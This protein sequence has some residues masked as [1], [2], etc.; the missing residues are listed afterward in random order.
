MSYGLVT[1]AINAPIG[2]TQQNRFGQA[3]AYLPLSQFFLQQ[4][5][6]QKGDKK[7]EVL[8]G[9]QEP[10]K[11]PPAK[12]GKKK[13]RKEK[14]KD[15]EEGAFYA[16]DAM[17]GVV[18]LLDERRKNR[19]KMKHAKPQKC[20]WC[21]EAATTA[22]IHSNAYA[23]VPVCTG[24]VEKAKKTVGGEF[25][26]TQ[27]IMQAGAMCELCDNTAS[28]LV[29]SM[30]FDS[31]NHP[32]GA[33]VKGACKG[34]LEKI[35]GQVNN[36]PSTSRH[37]EPIVSM[38]KN[39]KEESSQKGNRFALLFDERAGRCG[40]VAAS[41]GRTK[42]T[43][44]QK[45]RKR[46]EK[47]KTEGLPATFRDVAMSVS[48]KRNKKRKKE[49]AA[50]S[51]I[52][53]FDDLVAWTKAEAM[54]VFKGGAAGPSAGMTGSGNIPAVAVPIGAPDGGW[55][56]IDAPKVI[57]VLDPDAEKKRERWRERRKK[58]KKGSL[59]RGIDYLLRQV[60]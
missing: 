55:G 38:L 54:T 60:W 18:G 34:C 25:C 20:K 41:S 12:P 9:K 14:E 23:Y 45:R 17:P 4:G 3:R 51:R 47:E 58:G 31:K 39:G 40:A 15:R 30:A 7:R 13:G 33:M 32:K 2:V 49:K 37:T 42:P 44:V 50:E 27:P 43:E 10:E 52:A 48:K 26:Y 59:S 24:H 21:D 46:Y 28:Y 57:A 53:T 19:G 36:D 56:A 5:G 6:G 8:T 1:R 35:R 29:Y 22:V 16:I 11:A